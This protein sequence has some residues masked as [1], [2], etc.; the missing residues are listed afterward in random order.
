MKKR[1]LSLSLLLAVLFSICL[2]PAQAKTI[3]SARADN[4]FFYAKNAQGKSVLLKVIPLSELK[5]LAHGRTETENYYI[6]NTDNYPTTQYCEGWGFTVQELLDYVKQQT[7]VQGA[8]AL[9]FSGSD[10]LRLMATDSY[11]GYSRSWTYDQLYGV[12]RYYFGGLYGSWN[13]GWEIGGEN[14]SKFGI[15]LEEYNAKYKDTD[16]NYASKRAVF[17]S[18]VSTQV[19]LMTDSYSG[20]TTSETLVASS[21]PGLAGYIRDNNGVVAGCLKNALK[22]DY[23]LR[24]TLPMTEADLMSGHRTAYDNFKWIYNMQLD[25]TDAPSLPSGGTV[26]EAVSTFRLSGDTL[27]ISFSTETAGASI[28]Y[29]FDGAPQTRYTGPITVNV[30]GRDLDADPVTVYATAVKEGWDDAGVITYKYPGMAPN[31][32]TVYSGMAGQELQFQAVAGVSSADWNAW[33]QAMNF[34]SMRAPGSTGYVT[35]DKTKYRVDN[36][37]KTIT[38]DKS[39]FSVAGSYSFVFHAT[40]YANKNQTVTIKTAAPK[41]SAAAS[42]PFGAALTISFDSADYQRALSVY[43]TPEGGK[44]TMIPVSYLDRSSAG[45]VTIKAEYFTAAASAMSQAGA[46]TLEL[47]NNSYAPASQTVQIV[48]GAGFTDVPAGA[49]YTRY[50]TELASAGV[51]AGVGGGLFDPDG[52]LTWGQAMK[53]LMLTTGYSE[54]KPTGEHWASGYM[55]KAAADGL[56]AAGTDAEAP[57]SRLAFCQTAAKALKLGGVQTVSPFVDTK[58]PTVLALYEKGIINGTSATTFSP[59]ETL[60]RAQISKIIWCIRNLEAE[61]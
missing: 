50:V 2:V 3:T 44:R 56:I 35:L 5:T 61:S 20:R 33:T 17:Q 22:D 43:V 42:Y 39:L 34:I 12:Q 52:T 14:D 11:G 16:P 25:M 13:T 37:A 29:S 19:V 45:K 55:D 21:E 24:F 51:I 4:V 54:Q 59:E 40:K 6:S 9:R 47:V 27:T 57:I 18:G 53:L 60:T 8:S 36:T 23:A 30:K 32:Q 38:F 31:F 48:L 26:A 46:Y 58:D 49:W 15:T 7:S 41:L 1:L 10:T 28:Y